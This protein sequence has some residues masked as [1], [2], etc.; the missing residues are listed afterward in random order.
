MATRSR[1]DARDEARQMRASQVDT[2]SQGGP[3]AKGKKEGPSLFPETEALLALLSK[4]S[5]QDLVMIA[6]PSHN[7][8]NKELGD[9]LIGE[10]ASNA[11]K[12][13]ADLFKGGTA[14]KAHKGVYKTDEG[15]Y[16]WDDP[17]IVES[18]AHVEAIHDPYNLNELVGFA[19]RMGKALD[20]AAIM[21][22]FGTVMYY[23]EDYSGV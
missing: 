5:E 22:V 23:V 7:R 6:V 14:Y 12:L 11:L 20:Q 8:N 3:M 4:E 10:W 9:A 1:E 13:M 15:Q 16:L 18:F 2:I 21:L 19:K 17:I